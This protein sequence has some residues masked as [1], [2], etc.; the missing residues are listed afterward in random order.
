MFHSYHNSI[1]GTKHDIC[2]DYSKRAEFEDCIMTVIADGVGS[3]ELSDIGS[4]TITEAVIDYFSSGY[5]ASLSEYEAVVLLKNAYS[6]A[7]NVI[8]DTAN[9]E[10]KDKYCYDSTLSVVII[11]SKYVIWGHCGDGAI[12]KINTSGF[13]T[14]IT[15]EQTGDFSGEVYAFLSGEKYWSFGITPLSNSYAFLMST[16]GILEFLKLVLADPSDKFIFNVIQQIQKREFE[17]SICDDL[18]KQILSLKTIADVTHDDKTLA[19]IV[20]DQLSLKPSKDSPNPI[21]Y[22]GINNYFINYEDEDYK[23]NVSDV[24]DIDVHNFAIKE[25]NSRMV[26]NVPISSE[27]RLMQV[28]YPLRDVELVL[29]PSDGTKKAIQLAHYIITRTLFNHKMLCKALSDSEVYESNDN[30]EY[31]PLDT[32]EIRQ[33]TLKNNFMIEEL[34]DFN[35]LSINLFLFRDYFLF[36]FVFPSDNNLSI[37]FQMWSYSYSLANALLKTMRSVKRNISSIPKP[38]A[39]FCISLRNNLD[40]DNTNQE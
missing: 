3:A 20:D 18:I 28:I 8:I 4:K 13:M 11:T 31:Y 9:K 26:T 5:N 24:V 14:K 35:E 21:V 1:V 17:N 2:E 6:S 19:I 33:N 15:C 29:D 32:C 40:D 23:T 25:N 10:N 12:F 34:N 16:D 39:D 7:Y 27:I 30:Y 36:D 38:I 22:S 37:D